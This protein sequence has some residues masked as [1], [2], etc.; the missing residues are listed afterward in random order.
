MHFFQKSTKGVDA[1]GNQFLSATGQIVGLRL[2]RFKDRS[3]RLYI[4]RGIRQTL[5]HNNKDSWDRSHTGGLSSINRS[6]I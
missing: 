5:R 6:L 2:E 3:S 4:R 1:S